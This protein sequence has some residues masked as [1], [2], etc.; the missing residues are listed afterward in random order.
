MEKC[1]ENTYLYYYFDQIV[2]KPRKLGNQ[3]TLI[4]SNFSN[5]IDFFEIIFLIR[6]DDQHLNFSQ[7]FTS[8]PNMFFFM[9]ALGHIQIATVYKFKSSF[10]TIITIGFLTGHC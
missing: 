8:K 4:C 5:S 1:L 2:I 9:E 3:T 7:P 10:T 6:L